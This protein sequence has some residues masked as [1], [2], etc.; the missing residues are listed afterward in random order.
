MMPLPV[1]RRK[2]LTVI[3]EVLVSSVTNTPEVFPVNLLPLIV[4]PEP[5]MATPLLRK[6]LLRMVAV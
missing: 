4:S 5:L 1:L 6:R 2:T 3:V